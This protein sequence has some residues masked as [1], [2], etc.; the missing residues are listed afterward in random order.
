MHFEL[1]EKFRLIRYA[2]ERNC[3]TIFKSVI[4]L[5]WQLWGFLSKLIASLNGHRVHRFIICLILWCS[6]W[7]YNPPV[8]WGSAL[9]Y[10]RSPKGGCCSVSDDL[11]CS[12]IRCN[13]YCP[14][15]D[16]YWLCLSTEIMITI[17]LNNGKILM[18]GSMQS[19]LWRN[20][21]GAKS[22]S[23]LESENFT[24]RSSY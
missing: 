5:E 2:L 20:H 4:I 7:F 24:W 18:M 11:P 1:T 3:C 21:P 17:Y 13:R 15:N 14:I 19:S 12:C 6:R 10:L 8:I 9:L 23:E 16:N 22:I